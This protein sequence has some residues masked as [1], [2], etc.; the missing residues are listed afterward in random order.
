MSLYW[1]LKSKRFL[2]RAYWKTRSGSIFLCNIFQSSTGFGN[3]LSNLLVTM[4]H[5]YLHLFFKFELGKY[6]NSCKTVIEP[7]SI[8]LCNEMADDPIFVNQM[9]EDF[10]DLVEFIDET[11]KKEIM[12]ELTNKEVK[13]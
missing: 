6:Q 5:E 8:A 2:G 9:V 1:S 13:G 11:E 12:A 7:I 10:M 4:F 3:F